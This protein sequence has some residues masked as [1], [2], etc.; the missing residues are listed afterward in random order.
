MMHHLPERNAQE[1]G[2]VLG[3]LNDV[4]SDF[5]PGQILRG[6]EWRV[7]LPHYHHC[8]SVC[9]SANISSP[10]PQKRIKSTLP[11]Y[12]EAASSLSTISSQ[13]LRVLA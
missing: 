3:H 7:P 4:S 10:I 9:R 2:E 5:G 12:T 8:E 1:I 6:L 13:M 11:S